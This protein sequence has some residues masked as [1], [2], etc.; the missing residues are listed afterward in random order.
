MQTDFVEGVDHTLPVIFHLKPSSI[1]KLVP[2]FAVLLYKIS[3]KAENHQGML[4]INLE[5]KVI[6]INRITR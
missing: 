4:E 3:I 1:Q 2:H 5:P 6:G